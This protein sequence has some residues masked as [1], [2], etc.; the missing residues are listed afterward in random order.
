MHE[1]CRYSMVEASDQQHVVAT[2]MLDKY[3]VFAIIQTIWI[4]TW[5]HHHTTTVA[6]VA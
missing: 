4:D 1:P 5:I 2:S 3:E 6:C